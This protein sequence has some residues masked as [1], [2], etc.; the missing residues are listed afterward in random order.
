MCGGKC[1]FHS[2]TSEGAGKRGLDCVNN[3]HTYLCTTETTVL[4][5]DTFWGPDLLEANA[6]FGSCRE[7]RKGRGKL[8]KREESDVRTCSIS[9]SRSGAWLWPCSTRS[10]LLSYMFR[11]FRYMFSCCSSPRLLTLPTH[12]HTHARTHARTVAS[13]RLVNI[14]VK[15][16]RG[17]GGGVVG[18]GGIIF[19]SGRP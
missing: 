15:K 13:T 18:G 11:S 12:T 8:G 17:W 2:V 9:D 5:T 19:R 7:R 4:A 10:R 1:P 6:W 16:K 3:L 14:E